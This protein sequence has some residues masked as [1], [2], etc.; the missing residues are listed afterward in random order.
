MKSSEIRELSVKDIQ[1]KISAEELVYNRMKLNH[2]VSP[3]ENNQDMKF[4]RKEIA[5]LK[6]ILREKQ[7]TEK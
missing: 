3:L 2:A 6:T 1:G 7:L 4:K 5:R